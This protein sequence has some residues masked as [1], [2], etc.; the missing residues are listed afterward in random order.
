MLREQ[1]STEEYQEALDLINRLVTTRDHTA[2]ME[3]IA[4]IMHDTSNIELF[5]FVR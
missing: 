1:G 3:N 2:S 5:K 4:I